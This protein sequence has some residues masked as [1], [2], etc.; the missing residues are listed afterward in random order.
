MV[1]TP[2][3][4]PVE[5]RSVGVA[6]AD[7]PPRHSGPA[8]AGRDPTPSTSRPHGGRR[9]CHGL[10]HPAGEL[11]VETAPAVRDAVRRSVDGYPAL[12]RIDISGV[13]FCDCS[14]LG[15]LLW[16]KAEA[17]VP[18]PASTSAV[19]PSPPS[20]ASW[21]AT[22]TAVHLGLPPQPAERRN[23]QQTGVTGRVVARRGSV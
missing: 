10:L 13:S 2:S 12:L 1:P 3:G 8:A 9:S 16:A 14:G 21:T 22:G 6:E 23:G 7:A 17:P 19:R 18:E 5:D 20:P 15:V 4:C 11:D